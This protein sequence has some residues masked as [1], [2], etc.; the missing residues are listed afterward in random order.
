MRRM[1]EGSLGKVDP[2]LEVGL[3]RG[4][5]SALLKAHAQQTHTKKMEQ[6]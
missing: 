5:F 6:G 4:L 1:E 3:G 2:K